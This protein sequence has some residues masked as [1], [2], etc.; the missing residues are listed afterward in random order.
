MQP[1]SSASHSS[2]VQPMSHTH[3]DLW[4]CPWWQAQL[5]SG[6]AQPGLP[7]GQRQWALSSSY[8]HFCLGWH[9]L[10]AHKGTSQRVPVKPAGQRQKKAPGRS[11]QLA[12]TGHGPLRHSST[13][14]WQ[15][16][17][18]K[19][20]RHSQWKDPGWSWQRPPLAQG[21]LPHSSLS[22][23]HWEPENPGW[24]THWK[25]LSR[26]RQSAWFRQGAEAH[27][28]ISTSQS[29]PSKPGG[30]RQWKV[31]SRSRQVLPGR[32]G[33]DRHSL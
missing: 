11:R 33:W 28:S 12:P 20:G 18:S 30:H 27:S 2:P 10:G 16:G 9:R 19:P 23:S 32:Q 29:R 8:W 22:S 1:P 3:D 24:Q 14:A 17:P 7:S 13:S 6:G 25:P 21:E 4:Q 15:R 26:S 5:S 31:A